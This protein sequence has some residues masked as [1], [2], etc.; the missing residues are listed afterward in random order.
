MGVLKFQQLGLPW[1]WGCITSYADLWSW[2]G[3]KQICIPHWEISNSVSHSTCT[4]QGRVNSQLLV[5]GSQTANLTPDLSFHH[6]LCCK[7]PNGSCEPIFDIYT[8]IAFQWYKKH[9]EAKSFVSCNCALN[10]R[11]SFRDS[12]SQHGRSLESVRVHSLTLFALSRA[13]EVILE[14]PSWPATLQPPCLGCKP[15]AKVATQHGSSLGSVRVHSL[16][17]LALSRACEVTPGS[18]SWPATLQLLALVVSP[19]LKLWHAYSLIR[20]TLRVEGHVGAPR[21][22]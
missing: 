3:L 1:L 14:S 5:V 7:C 21:W 16:T 11:E 6:N 8:S 15:K 9:F 17:L 13:C 4:H 22:D 10:I 20:N 2:W 12:N 19:R 18:P